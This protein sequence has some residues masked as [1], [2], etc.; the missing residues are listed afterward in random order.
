MLLEKSVNFPIFIISAGDEPHRQWGAGEF[1]SLCLT[2]AHCWNVCLLLN[3]I[4]KLQSHPLSLLNHD[5]M[6]SLIRTA[7][8]EVTIRLNR[9]RHNGLVKSR[10]YSAMTSHG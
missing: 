1:K 10:L 6:F 3:R 5:S 9:E 4:N 2:W 8:D 7:R